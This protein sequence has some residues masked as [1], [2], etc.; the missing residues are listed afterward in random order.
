MTARLSPG[1]FASLVISLLLVGCAAEKPTPP[2]IAQADPK[3]TPTAPAAA[4]PVERMLDDAFGIKPAPKRKTEIVDGKIEDKPAKKGK[5]DNDEIGNNPDLPTNYNIVGIEDVS[6]P[7][8]LPKQGAQDGPPQQIP[9]PP[10]FGGPKVDPRQKMLV[11]NGGNARSE[12]TVAAGLKWLARHQALDGHWSLDAFH[13][14]GKCDCQDHGVKDD[15]LATGLVLLPFLGAGETHKATAKNVLYSKNVEKALKYLIIKQD[16]DGRMG[17]NLLAHA[18]ATLALTESYGLTADPV[19]RGPAQRA[20]NFLA[21]EQKDDGSWDR[22][23]N[24]SGVAAAAHAWQI[25]ALKS[26]QL[27][28]LTLPND[29]M[30]KVMKLL[31]S[32]EDAKD[33]PPAVLASHLLLRQYTGWGPRNPQL[34]KGIAALRKRLP[35]PKNAD[36]EYYYFATQAAFHMGGEAWDEWHP[37]MRDLLSDAQD[38]GQN[39]QRDQKGSWSP[40]K[41]PLAPFGGRVMQTALSILVLENYYRHMPLHRRE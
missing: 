17:D 25:L 36:I 33:R 41:D 16:K 35:D 11:E 38:Q 1:A 37:K 4:N 6:K 27:A 23:P 10:G 31:D 7:G 20:L 21:R 22:I 18:V 12:G 32:R 24:G 15:V 26:G 8:P 2:P 3:S 9:P 39:A 5:L 19:L 29:S 14:D 13:Q 34:I 28:G 30:A 40:G